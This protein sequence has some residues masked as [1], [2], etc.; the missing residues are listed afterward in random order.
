MARLLAVTSALGIQPEGPAADDGPVY[1]WPECV[2]IWTA[3]LEARTQWRD[4]MVGLYWADVLADL[5]ERY[6]DDAERR[7]VWACIKACER[8]VADLFGEHRAQ[9]R[10]REG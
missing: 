10:A 9:Q 4:G 1:L 2:G 8:V 7:D 3:F 5:R 6:P